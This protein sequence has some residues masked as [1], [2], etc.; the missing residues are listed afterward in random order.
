MKFLSLH[1]L[2]GRLSVLLG[3]LLLAV[4]GAYVLLLARS[5]D[6]YLAEE[7]QRNNRDLAA[8]VAQVLQIDSAT[9]EIPPATLQRTFGAAMAINPS[10]KLY[11][12]GLNGQ[13]LTSSAA[14]NEVK[15]A[16][17]AMQPVRGF[18][19]G[20]QPL[21][22]FGTDPRH[23]AGPRP[24]SVV[25]LVTRTG[26]LHCYLYITLG[27]GPAP[28]A[29]T[30]WRQ[31]YILG[32]LLR[33]LALAGAAALVLGVVLIS[34]LTKNLARLLAAVRRLHAG[35]YDARVTG[36]RP[37]DELA[38]LADAFNDMAARTQESVAAL[39][40][41]D[42]LRRELVAN[43]SHDLRTPLASIE[44]YTETILLRQHLLTEPEHQ[45][46]LH[47]I[48]KNT[49]S[50]KRLVSELFELSKL[51]ARQTVPRPE[52][53]SVTELVQDVLLKLEPEARTRGIGLEAHWPAAVPFACADIGLLERVLQNLL[54][55]AL[56]YTPAGGRVQVAVSA[57]DAGQ[58][59]TLRVTDT[60]RGI[61][62]HDLPHVFD[63]FYRS[64]QVREKTQDG[65]GLGLAIARRIVQL[66]GSEL[67][68]ESREG[69]GT[70]FAFSLPV[71][72]G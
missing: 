58:R 20:R 51:E 45:S 43:I 53:F 46:Y 33:M 17:V 44:G 40:R 70:C 68:V 15:V 67:T 25:P 30:S 49:Q 39:R 10:I 11:L 19:A 18:L 47:T 27:G 1:S 16:R 63:R 6:Q 34:L 29:A 4:S 21:P 22:I 26:Q 36:I 38:E 72:G 56:R 37:G 50:L 48:L 13:I 71:Y 31:S 60:G 65:L 54:D 5:S 61:A 35:D 12:I 52:P 41:N 14:P 64:D 23:P 62:P 7:L 8:S 57:P 32:G 66:H 28:D 3:G 2:Q 42:E 24:F 69:E 9:N 55:N 59:L